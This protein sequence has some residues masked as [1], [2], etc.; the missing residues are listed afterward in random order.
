MKAELI[1]KK[2]RAR[3]AGK[4]FEGVIIDETKNTVKIE[5]NEKIV[6][7]I[8]KEADF[9]IQEKLVEGKKIAKRPEDRIKAC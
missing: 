8:K 6:T 3:Y 9:K 5:T 2:I 4:V 7:V 1:G